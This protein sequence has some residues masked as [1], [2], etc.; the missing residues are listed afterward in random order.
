M[1]GEGPEAEEDASSRE[2]FLAWLERSSYDGEHGKEDGEGSAR[3]M[4]RQAQQTTMQMQTTGREAH[5]PTATT[6]RNINGRRLLGG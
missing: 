3:L 1:E 4:R 5:D 2:D 6:M